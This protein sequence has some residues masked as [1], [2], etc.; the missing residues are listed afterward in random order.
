M[1]VSIEESGVIERKLTISVPHVEIDKQIESRLIDVARKARIPGFRPG[2]APKSVIKKRYEPQI[3]QELITDT[4]GT[5]YQQALGEEKILPAGL[6]SIEPT[7]YEAGKDFEY[8]ATIELFPEIPVATLSGKTIEKLSCA[9]GDDDIDATLEDIRK[10]NS[11]YEEKD[12]ASE[13]GDRITIDFEGKIDGESFEGGSAEDF[14]FVL[15]DGQ[16]LKEFDQGLRDASK[17]DERTVDFTFP[18]DYPS[19]D[20]AGKSV[21]FT[22]NVKLVEKAVLP[23]LNDEFAERMGIK[24]NG[25]EAMKKEVAKSLER[26]LTS[27]LRS[28]LRDKVMNALYESNDVEIPKALLEEEIDRAVESVETQLKSQG[29]TNQNI[30][31]DDYAQEAKRRVTLGLVAREIIKNAELKVDGERVRSRVEEM[32]GGYDDSEGF[33]NWYYSDEERLRQVEA[34]VLEEQVVE[35]ML[36]TADVKE[37]NVSFK[38]FMRPEGESPAA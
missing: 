13:E 14:P 20:V 17:G 23:E 18:E 15:G 27:R 11:D 22:V 7:P 36:E 31:R 9:V 4:I 16:M 37:L 21:V 19:N 1:Q 6:I 12:G 32:A 26:E 24:E 28:D 10:R 2:K 38:E 30:N 35:A 34:M 29:I 33:V 8:V 25:L 5:S 3:T